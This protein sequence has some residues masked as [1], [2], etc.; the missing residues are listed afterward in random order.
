MSGSDTSAIGDKST[1]KR[2]AEATT[3]DEMAE[4]GKQAKKLIIC[5]SGVYGEELT[6][7]E[8]ACR[9]LGASLVREWSDAVTH[10]VMLNM[11]WY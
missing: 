6:I 9:K 4:A 3:L 11:S 8:T 1:G 10:L 2:K 5:S 7:L